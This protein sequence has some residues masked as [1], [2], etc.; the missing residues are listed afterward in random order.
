MSNKNK[1]THL[2][3]LVMVL[4]VA[5]SGA[6]EWKK[7]FP[8]SKMYGAVVATD[9]GTL[10]AGKVLKSGFTDKYDA[11]LIK[12][13]K[14]GGVGWKE[15]YSNSSGSAFTNVI[16]NPDKGYTAIG[17]IGTLGNDNQRISL[18]RVA[19]DGSVVW[20]KTIGSSGKL[21]YSSSLFLDSDGDIVVAGR[22]NETGTPRGERA[23]IMK[24]S[25]SNGTQIWEKWYGDDAIRF[26]EAVKRSDNR[27]YMAVGHGY[28]YYTFDDGYIFN[29]NNSGEV[30]SKSMHQ[31][32]SEYGQKDYL[33]TLNSGKQDKLYAAGFSYHQ[34]GNYKDAGW[35]IK[36][37]N[38]GGPVYKRFNEKFMKIVQHIEAHDPKGSIA[39]GYGTDRRP[40]IA[41]VTEVGVTPKIRKLFDNTH[42]INDVL[43]FGDG[44][45][46]AIGTQRDTSWVA[47]LDTTPVITYPE[48]GETLYFGDIINTKT[49]KIGTGDFKV[50]ISTDGGINW[51][52]FDKSQAAPSIETNN[53]YIRVSDAIDGTTYSQNSTPFTIKKNTVTV[54]NP[55]GDSTYYWGEQVPVTWSNNGIISQVKATLSTDGGTTWHIIQDSVPTVSIGGLC[56]WTVPNIT[57]DNA[58]V[59]VVDQSNYSVAGQTTKSFKIRKTEIN[60]EKPVKDTTYYFGDTIPVTWSVKGGFTAA[61][62]TATFDGGTTWETLVESINND[63]TYNWILPKTEFERVTLRVSNVDDPSVMSENSFAIKKNI[64]S[65]ITPNSDSL[66][67]MGEGDTIR[68]TRTGRFSR[69]NIYFS[70]D[71]G[72]NWSEVV[73]NVNVTQDTTKLFWRVPESATANGMIKVEVAD[74]KTVFGLSD[75]FILSKPKLSIKEPNIDTT[76]Y[77]GDSLP[78]TWDTR[79]KVDYVKV[80]YSTSSGIRW[81][82]IETK[83]FN[84]GIFNWKAPKAETEFGRIRVSDYNDALIKTKSSINFRVLKNIVTISSPAKAKTYNVGDALEINWTNTGRF[85]KASILFSSDGGANWESVATSIDNSGSYTWSVPAKISNSAVIQVVDATI[86]DEVYGENHFTIEGPQIFITAPEDL[87]VIYSGLSDT[88]TWRDTGAVGDIK[89]EYSLD[90]GQTWSTVTSTT[91]NDGEYIWSAP[92]VDSK[93]KIRISDATNSSVKSVNQFWFSPKPSITITGYSTPEA[94]APCTLSWVTTGAI[95]D[96][97][98]SLTSTRSEFFPNIENSGEFTFIMP[99]RN[100][101]KSCVYEISARDTLQDIKWSKRTTTFTVDM[102]R[103]ITV[104]IPVGGESWD[105]GSLQNISWSSIGDVPLVDIF[106]S[107]DS[108]TTWKTVATSVVNSNAQYNW[109]VE[110]DASNK[111]LIKVQH[112]TISRVPSV[113]HD[114]FTISGGTV[115]VVDKPDSL[116]IKVGT[117][118]IFYVEALG[119]APIRYQWQKNGVNIIGATGD[120][121]TINAVTYSDSANYRCIVSNPGGKDTSDIYN[122]N[123]KDNVSL[124]TGNS[125]AKELSVLVWPNPVLAP[126]NSVEFKLAETVNGYG[127]LIVLDPLG[128]VLFKREIFGDNIKWD[129]R[130]RYGIPVASGSYLAIIKIRSNKGEVSCYRT[131]VGVQR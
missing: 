9:G 60:I 121:Y 87:G 17:Y 69:A 59:K 106:Y 71:G 110:D 5:C 4:M 27:G 96:V 105:V 118:A 45:Y 54:T 85:S 108:G 52:A 55:L 63:S 65:I 6:T 70:N 43:P 7:S 29:I 46:L 56:I 11:Q 8:L 49:E 30:T 3:W 47:L 14:N 89:I 42:T 51:S 57:T 23:I 48:G 44:K 92:E 22:A 120:T 75:V 58:L 77:Y 82:T 35:L 2:F 94:N 21:Y 95:K 125:K 88:I 31:R 83:K 41:Y 93:A 12:L 100:G 102:P 24:H 80:E 74:N 10:L 123:V 67:Y 72:T 86:P 62:I 99:E 19:A 39:I 103:A 16:E 97:T 40:Q 124:L 117:P 91:L 115:K 128:A 28:S 66:C 79:G 37:S 61:K 122:L 104:T 33:W 50:E 84:V 131:T 107:S 90:D 18:I 101:G 15:V 38:G 127:E 53:A 73:S 129:L 130:N 119:M 98:F 1:V 78:V 109:T 13:N 76:Y 20:Q 32:N 25:Y 112:S 81:E 113:S 126:Q 68:F 34:T 114:V 26:S 64:I 116:K 36:M 111:C